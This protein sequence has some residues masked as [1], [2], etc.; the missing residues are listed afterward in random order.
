MILVVIIRLDC[1]IR[2]N[3]DDKTNKVT[4]TLNG[5]Y[6]RFDLKVEPYSEGSYQNASNET[7]ATNQNWRRLGKS[8][9][10]LC[11]SYA[12]TEALRCFVSTKRMRRNTD[13][14]ADDMD[15]DGARVGRAAYGTTGL[16]LIGD[17]SRNIMFPMLCRDDKRS[18]GSRWMFAD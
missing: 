17:Y 18:G 3:P 7:D 6:I 8:C 11:E 15:D 13:Q 1:D 10:R 9:H 2:C 14:E 4:I 12:P 16:L 5:I